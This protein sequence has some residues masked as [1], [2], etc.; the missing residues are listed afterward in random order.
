[1]RCAEMCKRRIEVR[2]VGEQAVVLGS[3]TAAVTIGGDA[4]IEDEVLRP[5][6]E[7]VVMNVWG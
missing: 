5:A 7:G 1:M 6:R 3:G 2:G 4:E